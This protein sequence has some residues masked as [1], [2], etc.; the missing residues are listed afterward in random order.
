MSSGHRD[1]SLLDLLGNACEEV[2]LEPILDGIEG[3][4]N[5]DHNEDQLDFG[6]VLHAVKNSRAKLV[7][8]VS[9]EQLD[10]E[11]E[12]LGLELERL[13]RVTIMFQMSSCSRYAT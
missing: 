10:E 4:G 11:E 9:E 6:A 3:D 2:V 1:N 12:E 8:G 13:T 7:Q 5:E